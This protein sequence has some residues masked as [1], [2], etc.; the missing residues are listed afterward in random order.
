[1]KISRRKQWIFCLLA[2]LP[3]SLPLPA[4]SQTPVV[5]GVAGM[6]ASLIHPFIARD[7]GLFQKYGIDPR[8]VLFEGGTLLAQAALAGEVKFSVTSGPVT[9]GSRSAGAATI[10]VAGYINTLP[11]N[12]V[13]TK[14]ITSLEQLKGKKIA[15]SR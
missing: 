3:V 10:V 11:Y 1:M 2:F 6:S 5:V 14:T 15:I 4:Q 9:I 8:L 13:T 12:L 7:A